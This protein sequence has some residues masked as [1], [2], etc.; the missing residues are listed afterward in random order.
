MVEPRHAVVGGLDVLGVGVPRHLQDGI[1]IEGGGAR[2][3]GLGIELVSP[4]HIGRTHQLD[5]RL[6]NELLLARGRDRVEEN[7][8]IVERVRQPPG[9]RQADGDGHH[10]VV[11]ERQED[12]G[13]GGV[14]VTSVEHSDSLKS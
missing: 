8:I 4:R 3:A 9:E 7:V 1:G 11:G 2:H 12:R 14:V 13:A 10:L 5:R 6:G